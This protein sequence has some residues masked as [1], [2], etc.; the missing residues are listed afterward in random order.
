[1]DLSTSFGK[2]I[3]SRNLGE[4]GSV[5][6]KEIQDEPFS[7]QIGNAIGDKNMTYLTFTSDEAFYHPNAHD[8]RRV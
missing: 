1:M 5:Y 6:R 2:E 3:P 7:N 4:K 8:G